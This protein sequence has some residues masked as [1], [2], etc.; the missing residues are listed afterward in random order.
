MTGTGGWAAAG[1]GSA[2][3]APCLPFLL[4]FAHM[5]I[6][7]ARS[8]AV[9]AITSWQSD[10]NGNGAASRVPPKNISIR[11]L[12]GANVFSDEVMRSRLPENVYRALRNTIKKGAP[13]EPGVADVV[14]SAMK[15]WPTKPGASHYT[16]WFQPMTGLTAEKHDS[17]LAPTEAGTAIAEFSGKELVRGE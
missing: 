7:T 17:F 10:S 3:V 4:E 6:S 8:K 12:F 2:Q 13:L 16:H 14:A 15:D 11:Q 9:A 5:D 1:W